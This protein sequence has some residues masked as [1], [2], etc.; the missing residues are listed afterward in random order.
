MSITL[1]TLRFTDFKYKHIWKF[2]VGLALTVIYCLIQVFF[3]KTYPDPMY[4]M[5]DGDIQAD[6]L[7]ISYGLYLV[8]YILLLVVYVNAFYLIGDWATVKAFFGKAKQKI[9]AGK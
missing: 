4:F 5:P 7:G 2:A 1:I 3:L 8:L 6:I 9:A